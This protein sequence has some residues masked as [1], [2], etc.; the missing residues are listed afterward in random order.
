M[1]RKFQDFLK[2]LKVDK[3]DAAVWMISF[4]ATVFIDVT[5]GLIVSVVAVLL[6]IVLR[7]QFDGVTARRMKLNDDQEIVEQTR[8]PRKKFSTKSEN[9]YGVIKEFTLRFIYQCYFL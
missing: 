6:S 2:Y 5:Y 9:V 3:I 1:I 8:I 4:L 7:T